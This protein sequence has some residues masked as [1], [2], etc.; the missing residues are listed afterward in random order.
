MKT[1]LSHFANRGS[2]SQ[3]RTRIPSLNAIEGESSEVS[4]FADY[5]VIRIA[6]GTEEKDVLGLPL[7]HAAI[8][9]SGFQGFA[10]LLVSERLIPQDDFS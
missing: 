8:L 9:D 7:E 5:G 3:S 2:S 6:L 10:L 1:R 4:A